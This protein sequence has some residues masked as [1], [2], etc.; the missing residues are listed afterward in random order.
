MGAGHDHA[1]DVKSKSQRRNLLIVFILI[2]GFMVVEYITAIITNSLALLVDATHMLTDATGLFI[3]LLAAT[4]AL[5]PATSRKT[6][7]F[8]RA[9]VVAAAFQALI[10]L[11]VGI[12]VIIE[13][14]R[15]LFEPPEVGSELMLWVGI[16]GLIVN[17]VGLWIISKTEKNFNIRA[18][19]LEVL[20][21][22]LG[23]VA[24]I[25]A[26]IVIA[27][28]GFDQADSIV[29]F[30]IGGLII[31]RTL[32]LL[33]ETVSVL[34]G[35]APKGLDMDQVR[36]HMLGID[37]VLE[38][39][40]LH[41]TLISSTTPELSAHVTIQPEAFANGKMLE[42]LKNLQ[43]CVAKHFDVSVEHSTFQLEP[44]AYQKEETIHH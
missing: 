43:E 29:S 38:V 26:A 8:K 28:T 33:F 36:E 9:E 17:L 34:M 20:N 31:P 42:I 21:D 2:A 25:V 24:V 1:V 7:G 44:P 10:L 15:R 40:D 41:A 5:R 32:K 4:L 14:I 23:S 30:I 27:T 18:A 12:F 37:G 6:W 11:A 16:L 13:A 39:H 35:N 19:F 22:T 3:A